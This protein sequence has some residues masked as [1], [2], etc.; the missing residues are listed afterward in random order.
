MREWATPPKRSCVLEPRSAGEGLVLAQG[1]VRQGVAARHSGADPGTDPW[2]GLTLPRARARVAEQFPEDARNRSGGFEPLI[3]DEASESDAAAVRDALLMMACLRSPPGEI[4]GGNRLDVLRLACS[5]RI[6]ARG[7]RTGG[8]WWRGTTSARAS[9]L[10]AP[11]IPPASCAATVPLAPEAAPARPPAGR[12]HRLAAGARGGLALRLRRGGRS[13]VRSSSSAILIT[14]R[15][16]G[17]RAGRR[18]PWQSAA[19]WPDIPGR[20]GHAARAR[21]ARTHVRGEGALTGPEFDAAP[22]ETL[23]GWSSHQAG[24]REPI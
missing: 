12:G 11:P 14:T 24:L 23:A 6:S 5:E 9:R 17:V 20:S 13:P 18:A 21:P 10:S 16:S 15:G 3:R 4:A 8:E 1:R 19:Q 22:S 2:E 7:R